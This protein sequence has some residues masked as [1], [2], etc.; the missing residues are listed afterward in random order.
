AVRS[1]APQED[2]AQRSFAGIH[3]TRLNVVGAQALG[4]AVRAVWDSA[5]APQAL[6]YRERFGIDTTDLAMAV[7]IMPM[8]PA[9][10]AGI[11]FTGDPLTGRDDHIVIN[12]HWGLGEALVS[13]QADGDV[14]RLEVAPQDDTLRVVERQI[15]TKRRVTRALAEGGTELADTATE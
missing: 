1:S 12:A 14:D 15:G 6:A 5:H 4:D 7:V 13:G 3:E 8:L 11:A 10:A 2:S 9:V